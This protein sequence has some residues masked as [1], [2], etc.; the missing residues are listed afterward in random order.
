MLSNMHPVKVN[1]RL[2]LTSAIVCAKDS[3]QV[4]LV[5]RKEVVLHS[6]PHHRLKFHLS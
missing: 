1:C 3:T 4:L 5:A 6:L 2:N